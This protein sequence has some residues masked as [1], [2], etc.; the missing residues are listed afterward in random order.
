MTDY[1]VRKLVFTRAVRAKLRARQLRPRHISAVF[2]I[3]PYFVQQEERQVPAEPGW[4]RLQPPRIKMIG[5]DDSG[6]LL[7]VIL[8]EP[9]A[10]GYAVVVTAYPSGGGDRAEYWSEQQ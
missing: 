2:R 8:D 10:D 4:L 9:D 1:V 7:T 3:A 6:R 5:P